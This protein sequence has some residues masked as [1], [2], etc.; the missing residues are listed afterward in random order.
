MSNIFHKEFR[1]C[2]YSRV[3]WTITFICDIYERLLCR[4]SLYIHQSN[5]QFIY[6]YVQSFFMYYISNENLLTC[7][8]PQGS[9]LP[10]SES[11]IYG[12]KLN[13]YCSDIRRSRNL[14]HDVPVLG[15]NY[16]S[17]TSFWDMLLSHHCNVISA[18]LDGNLEYLALNFYI[19]M[20]KYIV[21]EF[22]LLQYLNRTY[23]TRRDSLG[24]SGTKTNEKINKNYRNRT[25]HIILDLKH[26]RL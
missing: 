10:R 15:K 19:I 17:R 8:Q 11:I 6:L 7:A 9:P 16:M 18:Y 3:M 25:S 22:Q 26:W 5:C 4:P 13:I 24:Y 20:R 2:N 14:L 1:N 12:N 21:K 23:V